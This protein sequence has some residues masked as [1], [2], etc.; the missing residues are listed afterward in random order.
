MSKNKSFV[1]AANALLFSWK[2]LFFTLTAVFVLVFV[3]FPTLYRSWE[4]INLPEDF[5]LP[6]VNRDNYY[7]YSRCAEIEVQR[8]E[9]LLLGDSAIWGMYA[10][11]S[12][13]LSA[14]L[15]RMQKKHRFGNLA[16]DGLHPVA[17]QTLMEN[18]GT[19]IRNR[20]VLIYFNPL[21]VNSAKYDLS[22]K[23]KFT[24]NHP[25]LLPQFGN[26]ASYEASFDKKAG[27]LLDRKCTFFSQL[28]HIRNFFYNNGDFKTHLVNNGTSNPFSPLRREIT[29]EEKE[30]KGSSENYLT[31]R[32][33]VQH[34]EWVSLAQSRQWKALTDTAK[35]LQKRGNQVKILIGG[36]NPGLLD[37][38]TLSG[39]RQLR[40]EAEKLLAGENISCIMLPELDAKLYA[41][42]SHP[43]EPG[44]A[45]LAEYLL[46]KL[47]R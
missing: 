47:G 37:E 26:I 45:V 13:T 6:Y 36:I 15:N 22:S 41:D 20:K 2:E 39:L 25:E 24:V 29:A 16:I 17:M 7:F 8:S 28:K 31:R 9:Y 1:R 5:R 40:V 46:K 38:V 34:W 43:L 27:I 42:A 44:Y 35:L 3:L 12:G 30:H 10:S 21:W 19:S 14:Q 23:E 18:F 32:I 33:P 4:K 11:N